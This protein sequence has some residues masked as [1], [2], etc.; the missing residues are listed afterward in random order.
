MSKLEYRYCLADN[1]KAIIK[2]HIGDKKLSSNAE[3]SLIMLSEA[4]GGLHHLDHDQLELFDYDSTFFNDYLYHG[5]LSTWDN[6]D[7]TTLVI[8]AHDM[9]VRFEIQSAKLD[10]EDEKDMK[11]IQK[12][13]DDVNS[14]YG[15]NL[16]ADDYAKE[17][18]P[19]LRLCFHERKREGDFSER[20]PTLEDSMKGYRDNNKRYH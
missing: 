15:Y 19:Y 3:K 14:E 6:M 7:L 17:G 11:L 5:S 2:Q 8:M 16:T 4:F 18:R 1:D 12:Q 13:L 9:A 10:P 20:H